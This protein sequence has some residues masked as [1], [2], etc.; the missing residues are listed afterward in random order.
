MIESRWRIR[1]GVLTWGDHPLLMGIVN[2]TP[3]SFSDGGRFLDPE[4]AV[5]HALRLAEDGA[6]ILD[7]GGESTRP[8]AEPV[9]VDEE[10][11]RVLPVIETLAERVALPISIDTTKAAVARAALEAGAVIV[12]DVS[13]LRADPEMAAAV[14]EYRAGLCLMHTRGNPQT[15][16]SLADYRDVVEEVLAELRGGLKAAEAA[17]I[18][19]EAVVVD[20]GL[21]FA[22]TPEHNWQLVARIS[23]FR[24]LGRP[25]LVGHSRKRF[26]REM[27]GGDPAALGRATAGLA[28]LLAAA[29]V[30]ILRVHDVG[31]V[32]RALSIPPA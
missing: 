1:G 21:G 10:L 13:G 9:P 26:L 31:L 19:A 8:G 20:P 18:D 28:M 30:R 11:R 29:G 2:V 6:D 3:D 23:R 15:M 25:I 7:I 22:K 17:G 12:N 27:V 4:A 14:R 16:Q 32:R 24:E 5:D